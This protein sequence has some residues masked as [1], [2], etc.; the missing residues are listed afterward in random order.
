MSHGCRFVESG[1][2]L[3]CFRWIRVGC[4][5]A[6]L[7]V[8]EVLPA[9]EPP[10]SLGSRR[11]LFVDRFLI[12]KLNGVELEL[13]R[14]RSGGVAIRYDGIA[15]SRFSFYTSVFKD[16]PTYRMYYRGYDPSMQSVG[17][18]R[19]KSRT[20]Y[21]ESPDGIHWSK[22][23]LGLFEINGS[24]LN[25]VIMPYGEPFI[26]FIDNRP[27]ISPA[28]RYK[29]NMEIGASEIIVIDSKT[30]ELSVR[31]DAEGTQG[32]KGF[33]SD[34]AIHWK[35]I[36]E[37]LIVRKDHQLYNHLDGPSVMFWSEAEQ[38]YV[39]YQRHADGGE[40]RDAGIRATARSTSADFL[41]WNKP[42]PMTYS[43]TGTTRPSQHL[44]V[45]N[46]QPYF[47]APHIYIALQG[48]LQQ[49]RQ[50]LTEEQARTVFPDAAGG[51]VGDCADGVL[52]TTRPGSTRYDFTFRESLI[53]PG[54]GY[55]NWTSRNN[56]P[57]IGIVPTGKDEMSFYVQRHYAQKSA[58]LQRMILRLDG[59]VSASADFDG[60]ELLTKP[61]TFTGTTLEINYSTSA[62]GGIKVEIQA[63]SGQPIQGY[64][65][66]NCR[67]IVGDEISRTVVWKHGSDVTDL[68]DT[69]V[70]LRFWIHDADLFSL[71]FVP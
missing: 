56:Y 69:P 37:G 10:I 35:P 6:T 11:E 19:S 24:K 20:C 15:D 55:R 2:C 45:S 43:D 31:A 14:P 23:R 22:P 68:I 46:T 53:R 44:Y 51:G 38:L 50:A 5:L 48:R 64:E 16:G 42:V 52:L 29:A 70:R 63:A 8:G 27:G 67:E 1:K 25:N 3:P 9:E 33:I 60:G 62:A 7:S 17:E 32:L 34:D 66:E 57:A 4:F 47:R 65:L 61:F 26:P 59:F 36:H 30:S 71:R 49:G 18:D 13:Q 39:C 40:L 54:L 58:H 41:H 28:E 12:A 21:A